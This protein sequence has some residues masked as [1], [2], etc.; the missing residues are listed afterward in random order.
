MVSIFFIDDEYEIEFGKGY[1]SNIQEDF[2]QIQLIDIDLPENDINEILNTFYSKR[3]IKRNGLIEHYLTDIFEPGFWLI[4][5]IKRQ[6][7]DLK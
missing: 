2:M 6:A 3:P 7:E 4:S 1:V 5:E